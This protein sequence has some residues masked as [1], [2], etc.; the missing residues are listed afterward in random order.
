MD[1]TIM[2]MVM[3]DGAIVVEKVLFSP[4]KEEEWPLW[5]PEHQEDAKHFFY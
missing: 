4:Q 2:M 3:M 5:E 1:R